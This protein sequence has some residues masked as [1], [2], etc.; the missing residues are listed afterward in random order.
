MLKLAYLF[1][2]YDLARLA[3]EN[4]DC[5]DA[6]RARLDDCLARFRISSNAVYPFTR[7]GALCFLRLSPAGEKLLRNLQGELDFVCWLRE[8]GFPALRPIPAKNGSLLLELQTPWGPWYASAFEGVPGV[9]LEDADCTPSMLEGYG[10]TLGR[11]HSLSSR[12]TP[13]SP[14]RTKWNENDVLDWIDDTLS[15]LGGETPALRE[16]VRLREELSQIPK[17]PET[18]GLVHYDFEPD[19]VFY[20]AA[21][22]FHAIDFEDGMYH[23]YALDVEQCLDSMAEAVPESRL[24]DAKD[25]FLSGYLAEFP[26]PKEALSQLSLMRRFIDLYGYARISRSVQ[27][28]FENE[29]DWLLSLRETLGRRLSQLRAAFS[30]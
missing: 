6:D 17:T 20:D 23:W 22:G 30:S 27:E 9:S 21:E 16:S 24:E 13:V 7:Q 4:W 10:R 5:D 28:T 25:V 14:E 1:E 3:L 18:Y 8:Q 29:P 11:L 2:N 12:Y 19:N 15:R 26:L